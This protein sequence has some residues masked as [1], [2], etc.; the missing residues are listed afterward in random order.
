MQKDIFEFLEVKT[1]Y[2]DKIDFTIVHKAWNCLSKYIKLP[3]I[4]HIVGTNGKGTTGRYLSSYLAQIGFDT[5]H[6]SSPHI[7]KFNE[8]IWIN[9]EDVSNKQL[10]DTHEKLC[11]YLS[12]ELLE[13]LTYFEY[14]TLLALFLSSNRDYLILEAGLG[15]EFDATN[16]VNSDLTLV[17]TIGLDHQS[18]L[19]DTIEQIAKTKMRSCNNTMIVG[20]QQHKLVY[21]IAKEFEKQN[22]KVFFIDNFNIP[23]YTNDTLPNYLHKNI[24]LVMSALKYIDIDID[25]AIFDNIK[26][27]G[28]FEKIGKN[29]VVDVG[30]NPLAAEQIVKNFINNKVILVYNSYEDKQ[31]EEVLSILKPIIKTLEIIKIDDKRIVDT[32]VLID[33]AKKQNIEVK[34]FENINSNENYL[35]FG[36]FLVVEE[37]LKKLDEK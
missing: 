36:S 35:V 14:T 22:I 37:F 27:N 34:M 17:T 21:D 24:E 3:Y 1:L 29:I 4:I 15:G 8:R 20:Y 33:V 6:Y 13:K 28:R 16:V 11:R 31:Y 25:T 26:M 19:G 32:D 5:L 9:Q 2:Y 23:K 18:F 30:H 10:Q 12:D 7:K